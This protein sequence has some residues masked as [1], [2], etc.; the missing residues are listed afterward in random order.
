MK[1]LAQNIIL[2]IAA[3]TVFFTGTG[4]T[5]MNFCCSNCAEQ[6]FFMTQAHTCCL[7]AAENKSC[8]SSHQEATDYSD[9]CYKNDSHCK[10]S[11]LSVDID[12]STSRPHVITPFVWVADAAWILPINILPSRVDSA[13]D[14]IQFESPPKILPREYLSLIRVLII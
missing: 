12:S 1:R 13:V 11:R 5:I 14:T 8:C 9:H 6:T 4:V 3:V 2:I 7:E 10:A